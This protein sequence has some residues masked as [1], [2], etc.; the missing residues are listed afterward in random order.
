MSLKKIKQIAEG[1]KNTLAPEEAKK[2]LITTVSRARIN[3]CRNC[4]YHSRH[5]NT[6]LRPDAH[7]THCGCTLSAKTKCLSCE[8]PLD[9]PK[10]H[11]V[12]E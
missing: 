10:W 9:I 8:C 7:C 4:Q 5:H 12:E 3:I 11:P 1:W 2:Q 6:P